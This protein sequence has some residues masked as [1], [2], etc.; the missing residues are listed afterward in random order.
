MQKGHYPFFTFTEQRLEEIA[1]P[2]ISIVD[3]VSIG[4]RTN[5]NN[6]INDIVDNIS[7]DGFVVLDC[8]PTN[9]DN[10]N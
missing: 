3:G 9:E 5:Y 1:T 4:Y 10:P 8:V 6:T 7:D 2:E